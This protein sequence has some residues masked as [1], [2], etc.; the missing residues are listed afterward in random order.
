VCP[1]CA[2]SEPEPSEVS[3]VCWS[4]NGRYLLSGHAK[5]SKDKPDKA[6]KVKADKAQ[7]R[8]IL[9][10]VLAGTQV[11]RLRGP[12]VYCNSRSSGSRGATLHS[13]LAADEVLGNSSFGNT[14]SKLPAHQS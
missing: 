1:C 2:C 9:W 8:I 4:S 13:S 7:N 3:S 11:R 10:D 6:D 14:A 12:T 5:P